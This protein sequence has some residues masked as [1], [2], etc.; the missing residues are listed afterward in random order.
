MLKSAELRKQRAK[1]AADA[2]KIM[3]K[4]HT[5]TRSMSAEES[6][7]FDKLHADA[8]ALKMQIDQVE[9]QEKLDLE[10]AETRELPDDGGSENHEDD[11]ATVEKRSIAYRN[12]MR[13]GASA[14]PAEQRQLLTHVSLASN[15]LPA[16]IRALGVASG[17]VGGYTVP[18]GFGAKIISSMKDFDGVRRAPVTVITLNNGADLPYPTN[19]DTGN[20]GEM[21][22]DNVQTATQDTTIGQVTLKAFIFSSKVI[23]ASISLI[24]DSGLDIESFIGGIAGTRIGRA[25]A[26]YHTTGTGTSQPQGIIT[27]SSASGVTLSLAALAGGSA[28]SALNTALNGLYHSVDPAYRTD[29]SCG[30]MLN[31]NMVLSIK[32]VVDGQGRPLWLPGIGVN[33]PDT[34]L[35][36]PYTVNQNMALGDTAAQKSILFGAMSAYTIRDVNGIVLMR[37]VERYADYFQVGFVAFQRS[38]GRVTNS[39]AL[40][41]L[42]MAA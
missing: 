1:L 41:T 6:E 32:K 23:L 17:A 3:E 40:K 5:E 10:L 20:T 21:I 34:I 14:L 28:A 30:W 19:D 35:G 22:G 36:K 7:K 29:P 42:A 8:D 33:A 13:Y 15:D 31:D 16:E 39:G 12:Y 27:G 38:D 37:L 9:R 18:Q 24:Q 4:A 2:A 25:Q 26:A 11:K